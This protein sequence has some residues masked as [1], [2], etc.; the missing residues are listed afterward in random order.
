M[1]VLD[2]SCKK[3]V[4]VCIVP[5]YIISFCLC[6]GTGITVGALLSGWGFGK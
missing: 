5:Y 1:F 2:R 6:T 4:R 3:V